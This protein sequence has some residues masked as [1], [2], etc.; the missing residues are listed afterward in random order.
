LAYFLFLQ[1]KIKA[2]IINP[3]TAQLRKPKPV[4]RV[5]HAQLTVVVVAAIPRVPSLCQYH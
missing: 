4:C 3:K 5:A 2:I 1:E